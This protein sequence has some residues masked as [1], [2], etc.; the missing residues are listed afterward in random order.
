MSILLSACSKRRC[1]NLA[2]SASYGDGGITK[3][4]RNAGADANAKGSKIPGNAIWRL[5]DRQLVLTAEGHQ[6]TAYKMLGP[7]RLIDA[8]S[9]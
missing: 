8:G 3:S 1:K 5:G 9:T 2:S 4:P 7:R 6:L